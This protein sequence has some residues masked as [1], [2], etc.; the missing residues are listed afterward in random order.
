MRDI[1]DA[2]KVYK[3]LDMCNATICT[4]YVCTRAQDTKVGNTKSPRLFTLK[5]NCLLRSFFGVLFFVGH[6]FQTK[7]LPWKIRQSS[8]FQRGF[9]NTLPSWVGFCCAKRE[10]QH[11]R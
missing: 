9:A 7:N 6:C 5:T 10:S 1:F 11:K 2:L 4:V 3:L 8:L